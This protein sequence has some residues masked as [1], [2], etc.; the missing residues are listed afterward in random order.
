VKDLAG[1]V[2]V[3]TG[4]GSGIGQ[5]T[6]LALSAAGMHIVVADIDMAAAE[7][8]AGQVRETGVRALTVRVDVADLGSVQQMADSAYDEFG[9]VHV[10]HNN[11]GLADLR[12]PFGSVPLAACE[13]LMQVNI[14]GVYYGMQT[15]IP[16]LKAQGGEAHIVNSASMAGL[17]ATPDL[18]IYNASKFA[19][20]ALSETV[21][22][23]LAPFGIGVSVLCPG[24]VRSNIDAHANWWGNAKGLVR[25]DEP[26]E[27]ENIVDQRVVEAIDAGRM[28]QH[29]IETNDPYV[30]THPELAFSVKR[31]F[32]R[33]MA[34]F[35]RAEARDA[36][37]RP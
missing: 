27:H 10:L 15:F 31:R 32:E 28:V 12:G 23:E 3:I 11:A 17:V 36:A 37:L 7:T 26:P 4:A 20:V 22:F 9:A 19:V 35:E 2:A 6:A 1:K 16:R 21:R 29:A 13:R 34:A 33:V 30:L 8:V 25:E 24:R 5:G 14:W 18:A